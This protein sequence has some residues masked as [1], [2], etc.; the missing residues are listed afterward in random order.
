MPKE[1][2]DLVVVT[3]CKMVMNLQCDEALKMVNV[4][5]SCSSE[6]EHQAPL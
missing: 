4:I 2:T 3:N 1:D 5:L 6:A